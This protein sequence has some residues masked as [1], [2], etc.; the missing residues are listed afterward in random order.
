MYIIA[1]FYMRV[2]NTTCI[3]ISIDRQTNCAT[4][5][6]YAC[7]V[8]TLG[9]QET[10]IM[11]D[12]GNFNMSMQLGVCVELILEAGQELERLVNGSALTVANTASGI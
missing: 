4:L 5:H 11:V 2:S 1:Y 10:A 8:A 3:H 12:E 9:F 6:I 7:T